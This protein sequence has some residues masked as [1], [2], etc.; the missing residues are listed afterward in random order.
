MS[1]KDVMIDTD[2]HLVNDNIWSHLITIQS[3]GNKQPLFFI[4]PAVPL[5]TCY[6]HLAKYL[7]PDQPLYA[8][9]SQG[10]EKDQKPLTT[11]EDMAAM[12][13]QTIQSIQ[14]Q[15]PY[16]LAGWSFG[17]HIVFE[18]A[19]QLMAQSQKISFLGST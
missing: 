14:P 3:T 8:L 7:S 4:H 13:I 1:R 15:G 11:V 18:M 19:Q 6:Y 10:L 2:T 12:Y 16:F 5:S 9:Q 17:G